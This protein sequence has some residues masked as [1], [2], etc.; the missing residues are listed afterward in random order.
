[1]WPECVQKSPNLKGL[2]EGNRLF[3]CTFLELLLFNRPKRKL[4]STACWRKAPRR[5]DCI[6]P[7]DVVVKTRALIEEAPGLNVL[8]SLL[9]YVPAFGCSPPR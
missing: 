3:P 2:V 1:M 7:Q 9:Y 8:A 4:D 5:K 6:Y